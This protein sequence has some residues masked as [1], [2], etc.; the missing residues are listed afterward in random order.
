ME[1]TADLAADQETGTFHR[2]NVQLKVSA[3]SKFNKWK[4]EWK[5]DC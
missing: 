5:E 2:E 4:V 1:K 3:S